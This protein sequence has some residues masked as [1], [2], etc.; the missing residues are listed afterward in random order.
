MGI[1]NF[2]QVALASPSLTFTPYPSSAGMMILY[3]RGQGVDDPMQITMDSSV[4]LYQ[5]GFY[6]ARPQGSAFDLADIERVEV[7]R[8]PQGML[9]GQIGRASCRERL[10][11]LV[12]L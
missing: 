6:I 9:Y 1:T 7:L 10:N 8:G 11:V 3:L 2:E 4:G 12:V 5:D